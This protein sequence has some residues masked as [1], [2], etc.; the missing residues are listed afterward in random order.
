MRVISLFIE[1]L[2][3]EMGRMQSDHRGVVAVV[4]ALVAI[5]VL[6]GFAALAVGSNDRTSAQAKD[7]ALPSRFA[8]KGS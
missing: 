6:A 7:A 3:A 5:P 2:A 8:R 4:I 1:H